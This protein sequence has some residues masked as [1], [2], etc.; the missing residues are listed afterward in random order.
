MGIKS[1][2]GYLI[3]LA[4]GI[5]I[6]CAVVGT[7]AAASS[8]SAS[9]LVT[10]APVV[11]SVTHH[12]SLAAS[13]FA[14]DGLHNVAEDYFNEWDPSTLSNQDAGRCF[15]AGLSLPPAAT[16]KSVTAYYLDGSA[17]MYFEINR[18]DLLNHT[19]STVVNFD[20]TP[21]TTQAYTAKSEPVPSQYAAVDMAD[22]A[23][24]VGVCPSGNTAFSGLTITYTV[25]GS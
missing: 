2:F 3:T 18:Q 20:T 9:P 17:T 14:P 23:Y 7:A 4:A 6:G 1:R 12:Y 15:D 16:L 8:A 13:A 11:T 10:K 5:A 21:A 22:Y 25:P 24:S 19:S